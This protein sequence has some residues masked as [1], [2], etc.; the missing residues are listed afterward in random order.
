MATILIVDD[1]EK[2]RA[3]LEIFLK[4]KNHKI[5]SADNG[6]IAINVLKKMQQMPDLIIMDVMMPE[7]DGYSTSR[8]IR[9]EITKTVPILFL[10]VRDSS[11]DLVT[12]FDAGG[13]EFMTKPFEYEKLE[14]VIK[15]LL[16]SPSSQKR[17]MRY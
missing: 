10:T 12:G 5:L 3:V 13:T 17:I 16:S 8:I 4:S 2:I 1:D 9:K 7:L 6:K 14:A 15:K 11:N